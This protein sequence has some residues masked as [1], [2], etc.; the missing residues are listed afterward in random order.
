[1]LEEAEILWNVLDE[2]G[3]HKLPKYLLVKYEHVLEL[4]IPI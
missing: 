3:I 4:K 1:M 2:H